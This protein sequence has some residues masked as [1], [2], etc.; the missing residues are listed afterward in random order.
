VPKSQSEKQALQIYRQSVKGELDVCVPFFQC[1]VVIV[2]FAPSLS[3]CG[4]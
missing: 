3:L 4:L 1:H 2:G